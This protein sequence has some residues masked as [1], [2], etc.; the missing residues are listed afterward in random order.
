MNGD[1]RT[2]DGDLGHRRLRRTPGIGKTRHGQAS[3]NLLSHH[4]AREQ[5]DLWIHLVTFALSWSKHSTRVVI[6]GET[7]SL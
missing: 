7:L 4:I 2:D 6:N 1:L 5:E 3:L